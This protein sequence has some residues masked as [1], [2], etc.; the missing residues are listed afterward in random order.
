MT[1][2]VWA[3]YV[4]TAMYA[5]RQ[6]RAHFP[7]WEGRAELAASGFA[8]AMLVVLSLLVVGVGYSS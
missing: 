2:L 8:L 1:L 6:V 4:L 5:Y 7:H 3:A